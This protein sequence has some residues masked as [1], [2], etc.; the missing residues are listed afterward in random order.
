MTAWGVLIPGHTPFYLPF[1]RG[2]EL[3]A[4]ASRALT[5]ISVTENNHVKAQLQMREMMAAGVRGIIAASLGQLV[6]DEFDTDEARIPFVYCD[7]PRQE[8]ESIVFDD[9]GAG[10]ALAEH[11]GGD[12]HRRI[13]FMTPTLEYPNMAALHRGFLRAADDG[14][15]DGVDHLPC[16]DFGVDA[17][18]AAATAALSGGEPP[19]AIVTSAD[20]LAIGVIASARTL[21]VHIPHQL[22][23]ASYGAIDAS[24]YVDP[25]ITTVALPAHEMGIMAARR[26]AARTAGGVAIGRTT[27]SARLLVRASCGPH[28]QTRFPSR[29]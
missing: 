6:Q 16:T 13:T 17:G 3:V 28:D 19:A 9:A 22:A 10:Y 5:I 4:G 8:A 23:L 29:T 2:I 1:L 24:G 26:L 21:G 18:E 25:P 20:E 14:I 12:G 15:I 27:L 7:Q 11:L